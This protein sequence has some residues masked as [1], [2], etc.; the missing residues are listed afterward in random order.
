MV[1]E[2]LEAIVCVRKVARAHQG[3]S[4]PDVG[5]VAVVVVV[6]W[7]PRREHVESLVRVGHFGDYGHHDNSVKKQPNR[8]VPLREGEEEDV[9][10]QECIGEAECWQADGLDTILLSQWMQPAWRWT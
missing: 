10:E 7:E 5:V 3:A 8:V 6:H 9:A 4:V 1:E 2:Q